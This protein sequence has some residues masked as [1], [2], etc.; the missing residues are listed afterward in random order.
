[1]AGS[2]FHAE[3]SLQAT[4]KSLF[5]DTANM[6]QDAESRPVFAFYGCGFATKGSKIT[7]I[8]LQ[9]SETHRSEV[10][11]ELRHQPRYAQ[12]RLCTKTYSRPCPRAR[13]GRRCRQ[14]LVPVGLGPCPPRVGPTQSRHHALSG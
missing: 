14:Q 7:V 2:H 13:R 9:N 1:M 12:I 5:E 11:S 4:E 6:A 8:S 10:S 3:I